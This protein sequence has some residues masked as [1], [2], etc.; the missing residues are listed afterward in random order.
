MEISAPELLFIT[1]VWRL[2]ICFLFFPRSSSC[3]PL[4]SPSR[5]QN[6]L[7]MSHDERSSTDRR[8]RNPKRGRSSGCNVKSRTDCSLKQLA[9]SPQ[10]HRG[11][12][13][14]KNRGKALKIVKDSSHPSHRLF[15]LLRH[16]KRYRSTKS[17]SKRL[18]NSF[19]PPKP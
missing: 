8:E 2:D 7:I 9:A 4:I 11:F 6:E 1:E 15:S 5:G 16:G 17:G 12:Y 10:T 3:F 13:E 14:N 18:L 19:Y